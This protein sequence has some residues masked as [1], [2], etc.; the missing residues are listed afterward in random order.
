MNIFCLC[1]PS[2]GYNI[3]MGHLKLLVEVNSFKKLRNFYFYNLVFYNHALPLHHKAIF[4]KQ[5][6][7][8]KIIFT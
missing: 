5:T 3:Y 1:S 2:D 6:R 8:A 4:L 7:K